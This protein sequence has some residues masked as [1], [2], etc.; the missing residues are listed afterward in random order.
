M[1]IRPVSIRPGVPRTR[2]TATPV[3]GPVD[4]F[5]PSSAAAPPATPGPSEF[6]SRLARCASRFAGAHEA[7]QV[8]E[9]LRAARLSPAEETALARLADP[10]P[11]WKTEGPWRAVPQKDGLQAWTDAPAQAPRVLG[12][13]PGERTLT[14]RDLSLEGLTGCLLEF[15]EGHSFATNSCRGYV[16]AA[17]P[18]EPWQTLMEYRQEKPVGPQFLDLSP[19]D[20]RSVRVRFRTVPGEVP[21]GGM[22][23]EGFVI[24]G[25]DAATGRSRGLPL[26]A[27]MRIQ[28][29]DDLLTLVTRLEP[30]PDRA[31]ALDLLAGL[32]PEWRA[33]VLPGLAA[34]VQQGGLTAREAASYAA[35]LVGGSLLGGEAPSPQEP[36]GIAVQEG[37][38]RVGGVLLERRQA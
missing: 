9:R 35:R 8:D 37:A 26:E 11:T 3:A 15:E 14:S 33:R 30:G 21:H 32:A 17:A 6:A 27:V 7:R 4:G 2:A 23:L 19:W 31:H 29:L 22:W 34:R 38:V 13:V 18:G 5:V 1:E 28:A 36:A 20:G 10:L 12:P 24:S 25:K 16:E